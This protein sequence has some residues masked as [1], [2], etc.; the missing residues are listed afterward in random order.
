MIYHILLMEHISPIRIILG[1]HGFKTEYNF[2]KSMIEF[3]SDNISTRGFGVGSFPQLIISDNFSLLNTNGRPYTIPMQDDY[4]DFCVSTSTN[5]MRLILEFIW[6]KLES[7]FS[8]GGLWGEDLKL[9]QMN[10]LGSMDKLIGMIPGMSAAKVPKDV[11]EKQEHKMAHWKNQISSMTEFEIENPDILEKQTARIQRI[12][13]GSGTT[14]TELREL[15][16]QY[17]ML[18]EMMNMQSGLSNGDIDQKTLAK[19]AK[20]FKGKIKI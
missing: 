8:L 1:Y 9:E 7:N 16:K 4:W 15:L 20:K 3:L 18:K 10:K 12:A 17:K 5:P 19:M 13:H 11:L 6:T 14:T 2:R